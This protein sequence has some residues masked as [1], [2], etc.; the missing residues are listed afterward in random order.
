MRTRNI[1]FKNRAQIV[2]HVITTNL[3]DD[4]EVINVPSITS[5]PW[6]ALNRC[7]KCRKSQIRNESTRQGANWNPGAPFQAR[8][9]ARNTSQNKR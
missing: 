3:R 8:T 2:T 4:Y 1:I 7:V 5:H 6:P 9:T